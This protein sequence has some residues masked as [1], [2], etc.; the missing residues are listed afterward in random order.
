ML[1]VAVNRAGESQALPAASDDE[2]QLVL[3]VS[4]EPSSG[5]APGIGEE[6]RL[7]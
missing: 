4:F 1:V 7:V 6:A 3:L 2:R 5:S